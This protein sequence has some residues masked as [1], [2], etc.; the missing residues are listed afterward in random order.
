MWY[1]P[2][3]NKDTGS[4]GDRSVSYVVGDGGVVTLEI[5]TIGP[6]EAEYSQ[7][8]VCTTPLPDV[9]CPSIKIMES[10]IVRSG[11]QFKMGMI[12]IDTS[13]VMEI[14]VGL[15]FQGFDLGGVIGD[16]GEEI[17]GVFVGVKVV[18]VGEGYGLGGGEVDDVV[19]GD[20][21]GVRVGIVDVG[22]YILVFDLSLF[23]DLVFVAEIKHE[24]N[25]IGPGHVLDVFGYPR[26]R[27]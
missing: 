5:P 19:V 14:S 24:L 1:G 11:D 18:G 12:S 23:D 13:G 17:V 10:T 9:I 21:V 22:K 7:I 4:V 3:K 27:V 8:L 15:S 2:W 6:H 20:G 16:H 26:R 25:V